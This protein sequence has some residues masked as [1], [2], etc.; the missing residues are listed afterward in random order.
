VPIIA[1]TADLVSDLSQS[2]ENAGFDAHL[3]KPVEI[4]SL[5]K[6]L[7]QFMPRN[8]SSAAQRAAS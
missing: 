8:N 2:F 1:L 6:T 3:S 7:S 5:M 4:T